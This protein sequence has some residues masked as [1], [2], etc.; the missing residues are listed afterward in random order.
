MTYI[1]G[2]ALVPSNKVCV[3]KLG[4]IREPEESGPQFPDQRGES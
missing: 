3:R 1:N 4:G 2:G